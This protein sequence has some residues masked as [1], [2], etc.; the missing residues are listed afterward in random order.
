LV[1]QVYHKG[2]RVGGY[3]ELRRYLGTDHA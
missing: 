2:L 3:E 1:P